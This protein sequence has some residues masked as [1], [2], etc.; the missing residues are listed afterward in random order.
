MKISRGTS[1]STLRVPAPLRHF[2]A[3]AMAFAAIAAAVLSPLTPA[4]AQAPAPAVADAWVRGTVDGQHVTGAFMRITAPQDSALV[5]AQTPVGRAEL[6]EMS[7]EGDT[8]KM[9]SVARVDLPAGRPVELK[10]GGYHIMLM[11]VAKPLTAGA[12]V[13]LTLL[14]ENKDG[15]RQQ[16]PVDAVVRGL[17]ATP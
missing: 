1:C 6:H 8:M 14:I 3:A 9:R 16:V 13:P 11:G 5:G 2:G 7:R 15:S 17:G 10:P 4:G 12:R